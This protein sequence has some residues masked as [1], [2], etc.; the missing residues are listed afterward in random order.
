MKKH[1]ILTGTALAAVALCWALGSGTAKVDT[2][3]ALAAENAVSAPCAPQTRSSSNIIITEPVTQP[4]TVEVTGSA[5]SPAQDCPQETPAVIPAPTSTEE[6][7]TEQSAEEAPP[8]QD[9]MIYVPGFGYLQ[10]EGPGEWSVSE[11]MYENGN[12][13]GIHSHL[14]INS[15][16]FQNG[17]KLHFEKEDLTHIRAI[18]DALCRQH[19]LS[20]C[21]KTEYPTSGI[22][23]AEYH[24]AMRGESWKVNLSITID[25]CMKYAVNK[26][27]FVELM[28]S[29]GYQVRWT[30]SRANITYITPDGNRC[31][32]Y[33]LHNKKYL[34]KE[35]GRDEQA[36]ERIGCAI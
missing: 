12:K 10:S 24:T 7:A 20:V 17:K 15:V 26:G 25:E 5:P 4:E 30:D 33:R 21:Q 28:E 16:S 6:P 19:G 14:V 11:S 18:S 22:R 32:D 9:G 36:A 3:P 23:Q 31:R 8:A 29:E 13:V 2:V 27:Q 1:T 35:A 34:R